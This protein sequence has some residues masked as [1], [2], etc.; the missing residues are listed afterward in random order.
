MDEK[1]SFVEP[2]KKTG[3]D[4][5]LK[6]RYETAYTALY[7]AL[8]IFL[9]KK[10]LTAEQLAEKMGGISIKTVQRHM[11]SMEL[12]FHIYPGRVEGKTVYMVHD[13]WKDMSKQSEVL[14][15][16]LDTIGLMQMQDY[17]LS[18]KSSTAVAPIRKAIKNILDNMPV[19]ARDNY[20]QMKKSFFARLPQAS[21][22]SGKEAIL[23]VIH[24]AKLT[25]HRIEIDYYS[26]S[27]NRRLK[28]E[29][30]PYGIT[31]YDGSYYLVGFDEGKQEE[32]SFR[33][34]RIY[35]AKALKKTFKHNLEFDFGKK[36]QNSFGIFTGKTETVTAIF[37]AKL[38][39]F[40]K[41]KKLHDSQELK[42]LPDG[43]L[44]ATWKLAG[45]REIKNRLMGFC[46]HVEVIEPKALRD[47]IARDVG[48][49]MNIYNPEVVTDNPANIG[50]VATRTHY[51]PLPK[52]DDEQRLRAVR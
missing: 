43:R 6:G 14:F 47:E 21:D 8:Q 31:S 25:E 5:R 36:L 42:E 18:L 11:K 37:D 26:Y 30:H 17:M 48:R 22:Y 3:G 29:V 50:V 28:R 39:F 32:R 13:D 9:T 4:N 27:S 15:S 51:K 23:A 10:G 19:T 34:D 52:K 41:E 49:M 35:S 33:L 46:E 40:I 2:K 20:Q 24:D 12:L 16:C 1:N 7:I 38:A 44:Q 45:T